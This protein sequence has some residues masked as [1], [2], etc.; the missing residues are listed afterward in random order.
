MERKISWP[1]MIQQL[2]PYTAV[3]FAGILALIA[4]ITISGS[5]SLPTAGFLIGIAVLTAPHFEVMSEMY[6]VLRK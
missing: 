5:A 4:L 2:L 6:S 3:A 1:W